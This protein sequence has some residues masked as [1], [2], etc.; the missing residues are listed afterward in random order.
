MFHLNHAIQC[1]ATAL[2]SKAN[3]PNLHLKLGLALEEKY[4]AEDVFGLKEKE[5]VPLLCPSLKLKK[6]I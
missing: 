2:K 1:L 4:L 6:V 5:S 3:D